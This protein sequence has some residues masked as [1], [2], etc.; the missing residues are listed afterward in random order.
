MSR[1]RPGERAIEIMYSGLVSKR[2]A[3]H[4]LSGMTAATASV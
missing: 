1:A 4:P 2:S 3:I